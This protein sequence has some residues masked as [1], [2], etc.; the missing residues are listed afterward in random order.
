MTRSVHYY[1]KDE[2]DQAGMAEDIPYF[3]FATARTTFIV[4]GFPEDHEE[5]LACAL[6]LRKYPGT[7]I[8]LAVDQAVIE[9]LPKAVAHSDRAEK[10]TARV[11]L[12]IPLG[13]SSIYRSINFDALE[14]NAD[15]F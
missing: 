2:Q 8:S 3:T 12:F 6:R 4:K 14:Q 5:L 11:T 15:N 13:Y 9:E 7:V 10:P 1:R